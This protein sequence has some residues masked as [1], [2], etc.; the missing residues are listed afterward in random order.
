ML[1]RMGGGMEFVIKDG[2]RMEGE[3]SV[4][5]DGWWMVMEFSLV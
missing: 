3:W 4:I 2:G 1:L 5:K